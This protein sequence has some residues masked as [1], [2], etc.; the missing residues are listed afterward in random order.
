MPNKSGRTMLNRNL[1]RAKVLQLVYANYKSGNRSMAEAKE[2]LRISLASSYDLYHYLLLLMVEITDYARLWLNS[3]TC[4][5]LSANPD[6]GAIQRLIDNRF[7]DQLMHN[8]Q[9][10]LWQENPKIH[11]WTE[12]ETAVKN[13]YSAIS[14]SE[15]CR[16]YLHAE[17]DDYATDRAFWHKA[18]K[19]FIF[20]NEE[21]DEVLEEW[22][23]YWNDDKEIIDTF[24][25]K[26]IK[27]F[28]PA[29]G[30]DQ[31]LLPAY[32]AEE[33]SDFANRLFE[34][35][36]G[37]I[38]QYEELIKPLITEA[39]DYSRIAPMD[40]VIMVCA[41]SEL[42]AFPSIAVSITLNEYINLAKTYSSPKSAAF[43]NGILDNVV[44]Q[45]RKEGRILK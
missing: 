28:D 38:E 17:V 23:L 24:V 6:A 20:Q 34:Q 43:V 3:L 16:N 37:N 45:L 13:L 18:Y 5:Q 41:V 32:G 44:G 39:W 30:A 14:Q 21:L 4:Y 7:V 33:D 11:H 27:L 2:E 25:Q 19:A 35:A 8:K 22:G 15:L 36:L 29:A 40:I 9:L 1:L 10:R 26:T 31:P 42:I 12:A